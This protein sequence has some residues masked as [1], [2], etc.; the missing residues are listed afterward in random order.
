MSC[1]WPKRG[2]KEGAAKLLL[3]NAG[4][5]AA[6]NGGREACVG[7]EVSPEE[8]EEEEARRRKEEILY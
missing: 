2:G 4:R 6:V 5:P 8:K 1:S 7:K 3:Y